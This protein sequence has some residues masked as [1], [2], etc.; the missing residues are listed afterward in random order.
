MSPIQ[1]ESLN[2]KPVSALQM[3]NGMAKLAHVIENVVVSLFKTPCFLPKDRRAGSDMLLDSEHLK[4]HISL[5]V[6]QECLLR[7]WRSN[8]PQHFQDDGLP[9]EPEIE[10]QRM[11][12]TT[13]LVHIESTLT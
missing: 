12:L 9:R 3:F 1:G 5:T 8:L 13:R 7:T 2:Q 4:T 10:R 6:E 11:Y